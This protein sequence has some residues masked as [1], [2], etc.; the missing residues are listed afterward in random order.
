MISALRHGMQKFYKATEKNYFTEKI[1]GLEH[2][3][4]KYVQ[5]QVVQKQVQ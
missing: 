5:K 1:E 3:P 4:Y 2:I